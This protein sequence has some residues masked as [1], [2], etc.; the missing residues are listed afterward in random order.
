MCCWQGWRKEH[1]ILGDSLRYKWMH[2]QGYGCVSSC[3][4]QGLPGPVSPQSS[5]GSISVFKMQIT[6]RP[7]GGEA[8]LPSSGHSALYAD[9]CWSL[10][11][12]PGWERQDKPQRDGLSA[13]N[14]LLEN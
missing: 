7:A 11:R 1:F 5:L 12:L 13:V 9:P 2:L 10:L 8:I 14:L 6:R 4:S 3:P